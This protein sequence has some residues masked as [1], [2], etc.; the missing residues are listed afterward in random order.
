MLPFTNTSADGENEFFCDGITEEII[1]ALANIRQL[2]VTSRTSSFFF[3][4]NRPSI[5]DIGGQ[6]QVS[7]IL[8]GS[9]RISGNILRITAQLIDVES[10][11]H[12]WSAT[13]DRKLENIFDIQ[14]EISLQIADRLRE[15]FGHLEIDDHLITYSTQNL[16][17]YELLLKG[18]H[19]LRQWNPEDVNKAIECFEQAIAKDDKLLD[20]HTGLADAYSFL[21]TTGFAP[22]EASWNK[23]LE[24]LQ[25]VQGID[26]NHA[27]LNYLLA[28]HA[29]FTEANFGKAFDFARKSITSKPN[30]I[31]AQQL[32]AFLF[33]IKNEFSKAAEHLQFARS[34]D[35]LNHETLFFQAY[36]YYR[37][38]AYQKALEICGQLLAANPKNIPALLVHWYS[39]FQLEKYDQVIEEL[40][41]TTDEVLMA[42]ERLGVLALA[43]LL[44]GDIETAEPFVSQIL[45]KSHQNASPQADAYAFWIYAQ[46]GKVDEAFGV[47][48][49]LFTHQSSILLL[50][51]HDILAKG[52]I[53]DTRY[54]Q[55]ARR[56]YQELT[57][58]KRPEKASTF[59]LD[60]EIANSLEE[61]LLEFV[62]IESPYLD[63]SLSLRSLA[64]QIE[65]HPNQLSWLLNDRLGKN[66]NEF[67]ND[68]RIAHFKGLA[69]DP[70]NGHISLIGLAFES[71]F[72]S[73][74]VFNSYFKKV[75]GITPSAFL[76]QKS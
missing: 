48:D 57:T 4:H 28:H 44:K 21:A 6:L 50:N 55:Y 30:Y 60:E 65:M 3:K 76:K 58:E 49:K 16:S 7:S 12:I 56:M 54:E 46:Q 51:Y 74:T 18:K 38:K 45:E 53:G 70:S 71:G 63:P 75:E 64:S 24:S 40:S 22:R 19:L 32:L 31:E 47:V 42:D 52:L 67:I 27:P 35:P 17:A 10:D 29:F 61:K 2:K 34:I 41:Q 5:R 36:F 9:V 37:T 33:I 73:K 13:W 62:A 20:A 66:F 1:N 69:I 39:L 15:Q 72:N 59:R 25:K 26:P 11:T 14:D 43:H 23:A 68:Y 8:E